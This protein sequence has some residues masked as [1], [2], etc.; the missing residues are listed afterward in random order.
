MFCSPLYEGQILLY[1][2]TLFHVIW[3]LQALGELTLSFKVFCS[4]SDRG[5][6][7]MVVITGVMG[8]DQRL[9]AGYY[10]NEAVLIMSLRSL[11]SV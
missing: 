5:R 3:R 9:G 4:G 2:K 7:K 11:L 1:L 6:Q 10:L 8:P